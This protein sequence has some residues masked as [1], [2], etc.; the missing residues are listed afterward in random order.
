[1]NPARAT[2]NALT[3][4]RALLAPM[5]LFALIGSA[6]GGVAAALILTGVAL[7]TDYLDGAIA[8][9]FRV[10]SRF[11]KVADAFTDALVF[12]A[13]FA[14]LAAR[15]VLPVWLPVL[16]AARETVMHAVIRPA[17]VRLDVDAGARPVGKLKTVLQAVAAIAAL[18]LLWAA[19]EVAPEAASEAAPDL[20]RAVALPLAA[21]AAVVSI[22]S[23]YWYVEPIAARRGW[24]R[25]T[26]SIAATC[27]SLWLL[28]IAVVAVAAELGAASGAAGYALL[29]TLVAGGLAAVLMRRRRD[30]AIVGG[31]PLSRVNP[32][33][34]LTL[35]RLTSIPSV[36]MLITAAADRTAP[37][38]PVL[39]LLS[40]VLLTDL[41]DGALARRR[42]QVT[43][44]GSYLDSS[45]DYLLLGAG[46]IL[47]LVY[48]IGT[49][50]VFAVLVGRLAL[51][52][53]AV[54]WIAAA[55]RPLPSATRLG[56]ASIAAGMVL[57]AV[58]L[59]AAVG[60]RVLSAPATA[61]LPLT[62]LEVAL[63]AVLAASAVEKLVLLAGAVRQARSAGSGPGAP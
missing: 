48:G 26:V 55:G 16:L 4:S 21:A 12:V 15:G 19:P 39:A 44:I 5:I 62:L 8:R 9:R 14:G 1:M 52:A 30:F 37:V 43:R 58:E 40:A 18:A 46:A 13:I 35:A 56:K 59:A 57:L 47:S 24:D 32:S 3:L 22:A 45:T 50:W 33:N 49:P 20:T 36:V 25:L 11:G 10:E 29:H 2:A 61:P 34:V 6:G 60:T 23:L 28:Q 27:V 51:Q 38:W 42:G 63:A 53:G 31:P 54:L 17:L 7:A 41:A